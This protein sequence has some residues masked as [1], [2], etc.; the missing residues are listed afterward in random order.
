MPFTGVPH[1]WKMVVGRCVDEGR[2]VHIARGDFIVFFTKP[3]RTV[4]A[5][6]VGHLLDGCSVCLEE[7]RKVLTSLGFDLSNA[8][9]VGVLAKAA[10]L[11]DEQEKAAVSWARL[12]GIDAKQR[13]GAIRTRRGLRNHGL[14]AYLLDEAESAAARGKRIQATELLTLAAKI[15]EYLPAWVYGEAPLADLQL[16]FEVLVADFKRLDLDFV[17]SLAALGRAERLRDRGIAPAV[18]ATFFR[19]QANLLFDLGDFEAAAKAAREAV[20]LYE[21]VPDQQRKAKAIL[22]EA[23][24]LALLEPRAAL[25][26]AEEGLGLLSGPAP[27]PLLSGIFTKCYCLI[28]LGNVREAE[29][30]LGANREQIREVADVG[31]ELWFRYIDALILKA[32]G[33]F[34]DADALLIHLALRFREEGLIK[35]MLF[36]HLERIRLKTESGKWRAAVNIATRLTP[37][38]AGLGLR[39]DLLGMWASLQDAL[40]QRRDAVSEIENLFRRRWNAPGALAA[41]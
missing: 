39:A 19:V 13:L 20:A 9:M 36:Q 8:D 3:S 12:A 7:S 11:R 37:E 26:R 22:Q 28:K 34:K 30:L 15:L 27:K 32:R 2:I 25:K 24:I 40:I 1:S 38:L 35:A 5:R 31:D 29:D 6:V 41:R 23:M 21:K 17:G 14:A 4:H 18:R 10:L 16:R 33:E